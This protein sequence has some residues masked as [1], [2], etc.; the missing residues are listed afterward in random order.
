MLSPPM[1]TGTFF[2]SS[3]LSSFALC[4]ALAA[5]GQGESSCAPTETGGQAPGSGGSSTGSGGSSTNAGGQ[6]GE[7]SSGGQSNPTSGGAST[8][9]GS[10]LPERVPGTDHYSCEPAEG[11]IPLLKLTPVAT[12]LHLPVF[13]THAPNDDRLFIVQLDGI[14]R[15]LQGE[16]VKTEPFL[17]LGD[18]VQVGGDGGDERGLL[19]L[20]FAP[21]YAESGLFYVHYSA[22]PAFEGDHEVGDTIIEEYRVSSDPDRSDNGSGRVVFSYPQ[23]ANN[24]NGGSIHF[25]LDGLLYIGLGDGGGSGDTYGNGQDPKTPLGAILRIDP[26]KSGDDPYSIPEDNL[27]S[28]LED[29]APEIWDMGL[30]NPFRFSFDA[31]T[32]DLY[33]GDVGQGA[34]EEV[35]IELA[36]DGRRN[37]GWNVMEGFSC[38]GA[39]DCDKAGLTLPMLDYPNEGSAV[40]VTG[41]SVYRG[42][43]I[44]GLRGAYF[45]ADYP[46]NRVWSVIFDRDERT[47]T[48]PISYTQDLTLS[49]PVAIETGGDGELYFVS[50]GAGTVYRL[51]PV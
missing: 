15:I 46:S 51:D 5:C 20:A 2:A 36:Q 26:R 48:N 24:H 17:D 13:A 30:R 14:V 38:Y 16:T 12:D 29:A 45:Y 34:F 9:G 8:G 33:I 42:S 37:Y 1:R 35:D 50:I 47:V 4:L 44:P 41:G 25:G 40:S 10:S 49:S 18:K 28:V 6:G 27:V 43:K 21:D 31:C 22:G 39:D 7:T 11:E 3:L 19:G 23:P 32:G